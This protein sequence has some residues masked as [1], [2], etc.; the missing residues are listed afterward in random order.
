MTKGQFCSTAH[1]HRQATGKS[2]KREE[3]SGSIASSGS[4]RRVRLRSISR[5]CHACHAICTLSPLDAALPKGFLRLQRKMQKM[6]WQRHKRIAP[7]TWNDF[8]NFQNTSECLPRGRA[9]RASRGRLRA[10]ATVN[11][12]SPQRE[13]RT[14]YACLEKDC[15]FFPHNKNVHPQVGRPKSS[16]P[17]ICWSRFSPSAECPNP[18]CWSWHL[19]CP[20]ALCS[21]S[22]LRQGSTHERQQTQ[23]FR[24]NLTLKVYK[25]LLSLS[26]ATLSSKVQ[27]QTVQQHMQDRFVCNREGGFQKCL[28][29]VLV[30]KLIRR[31]WLRSNLMFAWVWCS[32]IKSAIGC[33]RQKR[34]MVD[35]GT[36]TSRNLEDKKRRGRC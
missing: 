25:S 1:R 10:V 8:D 26:I 19:F 16:N 5:K 6:C 30:R 23:P 24:T 33:L 20:L 12:T 11:A 17:P 35:T 9:V 31:F 18:E 29:M 3:A 14:L 2:D 27:L 21:I 4:T 28:V 32:K 13:K 15:Y 34:K 36:N 7:A 22:L